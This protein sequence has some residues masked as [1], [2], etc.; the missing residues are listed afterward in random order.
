MVVVFVLTKRKE[1]CL[2]TDRQAKIYSHR[3]PSEQV[4]SAWKY[5]VQKFVRVYVKNNMLRVGRK[6]WWSR[7]KEVIPEGFADKYGRIREPWL[8]TMASWLRE[9]GLRISENLDISLD[10][11]VPSAISV[12][13]GDVPN[14]SVSPSGTLSSQH[15][16]NSRLVFP[17]HEVN[18]SQS[19]LIGNTS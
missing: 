3:T 16:Y 7:I 5:Y 1:H 4:L 17:E 2:M 10:N 18:L 12:I 6:S 15:A 13:L 9:Y 11:V 8:T 14:V 19:H